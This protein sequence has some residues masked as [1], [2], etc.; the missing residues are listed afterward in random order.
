L[1]STITHLASRHWKVA[2]QS[3]SDAQVLLHFVGPS[4][5]KPPQEAG[6]PAAQTPLPSHV[7]ALVAPSVHTLP[8]LVPEGTK[9]HLSLST[10]LHFAPHGFEESPHGG[11][12]A[13]GS[14]TTAVQ[15]PAEPFRLHDEHW[16]VQAVSQHTPSTQLPLAQSVPVAHAA[17][18]FCAATQAPPVHVKPATQSAA[19]PQVVVH[20]VLVESQM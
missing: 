11:R 8:Q 19:S 14:P 4:H 12:D 7:L 9:E 1:S 20:A 5:A 3:A 6:V 18:F 2:E 13:G 10:P 15:V 17:P 16:P